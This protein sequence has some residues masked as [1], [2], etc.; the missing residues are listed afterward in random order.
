MQLPVLSPP[1]ELPIGEESS[2]EKLIEWT[3]ERFSHQKLVLTTGFGMEGCALIEMYAAHRKPLDVIYLDTMFFFPETYSLIDK[4]KSRH[5]Y[6]NFINRGTT[7]TPEEQELQYGAQLWKKN[8]DLCCQ[9]RKVD[10]MRET[11][12]DIDVWITGV[13]RSQAPS[14]AGV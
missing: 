9:L 1:D 8:P 5:P 13:R 6:L 3:L 11:L 12:K 2:T 4:L 7:L 10:P 14:R